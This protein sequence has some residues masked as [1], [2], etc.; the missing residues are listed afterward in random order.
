VTSLADKGHPGATPDGATSLETK[1][2]HSQAH[3]PTVKNSELVLM[4]GE[5]AYVWD[6]QGRKLLDVPASLWYCNVGHGRAEIA[7]AV[8]EQMKL[9]ETYSTFQQNTTLPARDLAGRLAGMSPVTDPKVFLTSGGGDSVEAAIKLVLRYWDAA[10]RPTKRTIV[11]R[12]RGYHG[13]HGFGTSITGISANREGLG[14]L[15]DGTVRVPTHDADAFVHLLEAEGDRIA[16]FV[17]EP[18]IGTGGVL[19]PADGYLETVQRA[20]KEHDVAFIVDEVIT[21]FGRT[22]EMFASERFGLEPDLLLVAKGLTS[23]YMPLGAVVVSH[24]YWE[25]FWREGSEL[26]FRHG[27]TYAGHAAACAAAEENLNV[28]EREG[29]VQRVRELE[30]KLA[31][32]LEPLRAH[33]AV[34]EIRTG[35]GLLAGV[36][37]A[38]AALA[39]QVAQLCLAQGILIRVIAERTLG[40]SPPFVVSED[41]LSLMASGI[42]DALDTATL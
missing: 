9:L 30:A 41:D 39:Q 33:P 11:T 2:W 15:L 31:I 7:N 3:M 25:P 21:G 27:I 20:C 29:L 10:G 19:F 34:R 12:E 24:R 6:E 37:L 22:G 4:R 14:Q 36:E 1:L 26:I 18:I 40:I 32:V 28:L 13:L 42:A 38:D 23:G 8:A 16:A 5:G 35:A 17:C